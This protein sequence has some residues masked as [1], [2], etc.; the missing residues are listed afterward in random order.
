MDMT[1]KLENMDLDREEIRRRRVFRVFALLSYFLA[2][3][4]IKRICLEAG[5]LQNW[6]NAMFVFIILFICF[7]E[8]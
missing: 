8:A 2:F 4:Y 5:W 3:F 1:N 6:M 7:V